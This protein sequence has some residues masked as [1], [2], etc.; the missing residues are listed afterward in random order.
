[1]AQEKTSKE[2]AEPPPPGSASALPYRIAADMDLEGRFRESVLEITRR[3]VRSISG[4]RVRCQ[5]PLS[6]VEFVRCTE[7]VGNGMLQAHL[8]DGR[9]VPLLRYSKTL[10]ERFEAAEAEINRLLGRELSEDEKEEQRAV[11]AAPVEERLT[12]RC[13]NCGYPLK[14]Q[15]DVCPKC[16]DVRFMMWRLV[17][18]LR[19]YWHHALFSMVLALALTALALAP[20]IVLRELIDGPLHEPDLN[21]AM[22][23]V[24]DDSADEQQFFASDAAYRLAR[25]G[26]ASPR[27]I[28]GSGPRALITELDVR[29]YLKEREHFVSPAAQELAHENL[30]SFQALSG[31]GPDGRITQDDVEVYVRQAVALNAEPAARRAAFALGV[32]L[33]A[34]AG[35]GTAGQITVGDVVEAGKPGRYAKVTMLVGFLLGVFVLRG[36]LSF[37]RIYIMG[38]LGAKLIHDIRSQLYRALQRLSLSFYDREHTGRIMSRITSDTAVLNGFVVNGFPNL[39]I[40]I[41]TILGI[42]TVMIAYH[43]RL[44][45][46]TLLATPLMAL[47]TV[48]FAKKMRVRYR[49]LKTKNA[50]VYK[51][52]SEAISG[53]RVV[54]AFGQENR[55]IDAFDAKSTE[56]RQ[57]VVDS[58]KLRSVFSPLMV[59]LTAM[60]TLLIYSYGGHLVVRGEL[61]LGVL[62]MFTTYMVQFYG[63]VQALTQ[64]TDVFQDTAV[65]AERVFA[66]LDT[67]SEVA[68][69]ANAA[70]LQEIKGSVLLEGVDFAYERGERVLRAIN[71]DV[72]P[73]EII[74]LCGATGSG[75]ST[76]VKLVARFYDPTKGRI[77]LD[78]RDLREVRLT[79]L[80]RQIGMVLQDTFLFTGTLREN[81]AY[82]HPDATNEQV[83]EAARAANA[84]GFIMDLPDAYDTYVGERGVG[85]SGGERQRIAIAR[86]ILMDPAILILD[87]AT[88]A[89]DTATEA[90]IQEALERLMA[91]RT[92]FAIAH[93]LSTLKNADRLVVLD[94]GRIAEM[95]THEELL[96][97]QNGIYRNLVEIQDL[98]G[99]SEARHIQGEEAEETV[100]VA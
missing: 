83:L 44:A 63:P 43:W 45:L 27:V 37:V 18:Y 47:A 82:G 57:A 65:S 51:V 87:E 55:E 93:R 64:L 61:K 78:G 42:G 62:V 30:V 20:G 54:R 28:K 69:A 99:G 53:I 84:H 40:Y 3:G 32:D 59:F 38:S 92:T 13:P 21:P 6:N 73:G 52:V 31:S 90:L 60:G 8:R 2:E 12:Y 58:V 15:G 14:H 39:I 41:L 79:D 89:V 74:G 85:L 11:S 94:G 34:V 76:I 67:P 100:E 70:R 66:I 23:V 75:K 80:R 1:M 95:G 56:Y 10:S 17:K 96:A 68:E 25:E 48:V 77:L 24:A 88:S 71:L 33:R 5:L 50:S 36:L 49:R 91:G 81:I 97:K 86:A 22:S 9:V 26:A 46:L 19:P 16:V 72:A 35:T 7:F 98:L 4:G 29:N